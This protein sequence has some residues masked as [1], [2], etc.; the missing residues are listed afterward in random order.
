MNDGTACAKAAAIPQLVYSPYRIKHPMIR[1]G[2]RGSG[3]F[4]K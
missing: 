3:Q 1:T 4:K 2:E